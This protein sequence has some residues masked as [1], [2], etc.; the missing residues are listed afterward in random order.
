MRTYDT[1]I[2]WTILDLVVISIYFFALPDLHEDQRYQVV[3]V[4]F[5]FLTF[6]II[7]FYFLALRKQREQIHTNLNT[8]QEAG[9]QIYRKKYERLLYSRDIG[10]IPKF[11]RFLFNLD[12]LAVVQ[13]GNISELRSIIDLCEHYHIPL[14]P[15]GAGTSGYG[16]TLPI[17]NGIIVLL[18]NF[19]NIISIDKENSIVEVECGITWENLRNHLES[20]NLTLMSYPSSGPSSTVGGWVAQGGYG[21]GSAK[22]GSVGQSVVSTTVLDSKGEEFNVKPDVII[23]SCGRLGILWKITLK[24]RNLS[25]MVHIAVSS[26]NQD[27]LLG[28]I[29]AYQELH[30]FFLRF[31]GPQNLLWKSLKHNSQEKMTQKYNGGIISMSF[32]EEDWNRD[33]FEE[34]LDKYQ[35]FEL[36]KGLSNILWEER[37]RTIRM[38]RQGPSLIIAEVLIPINHLNEITAILANRYERKLYALEIISTSDGLCILFVWFPAD[39]R[40]KSIPIF[41]SLPYNFHWIRIFDI[42]QIARRW[43]GKPYSSGLWFSPYS[44]LIYGKQL[45][46]MKRLK[47]EI[48]PHGIF[49]PGKVWGVWLPRFFPIL[50]YWV[51]IRIGAPLVSIFYK[52]VPKRF[53]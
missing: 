35:L 41:G 17:R 46:E 11:A 50:P 13:P 3:G 27:Q 19:S 34:I 40:S 29:S 26:S 5:V 10:D 6:L 32:L 15:R 12:C 31:D 45:R 38:K 43:N 24:L 48:D 36:S 14:I 21:V 53:R 42:I 9:I 37:F 30:P 25:N 16:G 49:N 1:L 47:K 4:S 20:Q 7:L 44:S 22:F 52:I 23:G 28:A 51:I 2:K 33:E 39:I 18:I 8:L